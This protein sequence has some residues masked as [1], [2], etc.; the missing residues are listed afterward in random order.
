L[1]TK[2][3]PAEK[4]PKKLWFAKNLKDRTAS[5]VIISNAV[6]KQSHHS[7][8]SANSHEGEL[9]RKQLPNNFAQ[10]V[11]DLELMVDSGSFTNQTID[12]LVALYSVSTTCRVLIRNLITASS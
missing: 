10:R 11:L 4:K 3:A 6:R 1:F 9:R 5:E 2:K 7:Q 8:H 12:Q